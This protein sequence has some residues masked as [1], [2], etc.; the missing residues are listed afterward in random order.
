MIDPSDTERAAM[1]QCLKP[2]GNIAE[3]IG[4]KKP[5]GE[6]SEDDA[7]RVID[8]IVT[9]YTEAITNHHEATQFPS[10]FVAPVQSKSIPQDDE[11]FHDDLII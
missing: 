4:F 10:V 5:L 6:Y 3:T 8:A 7:L 2:F 1:R 11:V 9:A